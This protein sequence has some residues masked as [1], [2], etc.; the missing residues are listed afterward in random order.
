MPQFLEISALSPILL[1]QSS[2]SL[3]CEITHPYKN[4]HSIPWCLLPSEM[5]HI[6]S[7]ECVAPWINLL[8]LYYGSLLKAFLCGASNPHLVAISGLRSDL[9]HGH[10]RPP[11]FHSCNKFPLQQSWIKLKAVTFNLQQHCST[12]ALC[13][14]LLWLRMPPATLYHSLSRNWQFAS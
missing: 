2:H 3:V 8:S 14:L 1:D 9:G 13:L 4:W 5:A 11:Y 10:P 12:M 6:L 7:M